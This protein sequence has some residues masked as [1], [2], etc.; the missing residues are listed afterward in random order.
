[1]FVPPHALLYSK[2]SIWEFTT[3][4][5]NCQS[6]IEETTQ[7]KKGE[8]I[9]RG[10]KGDSVLFNVPIVDPCRKIILVKR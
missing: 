3:G 4:S 1:M 10:E 5:K 8:S 2:P 6:V 9:T 7:K